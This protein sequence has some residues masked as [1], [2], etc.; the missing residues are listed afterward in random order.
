M[1]ISNSQSQASS[2]NQSAT[3]PNLQVPE[4][5]VLAAPTS[6]L[7]TSSADIYNSTNQVSINS[8]G[9]TTFKS[10]DPSKANTETAV[11]QKPLAKSHVKVLIFGGLVIVACLVATWLMTLNA[12]KNRLGARL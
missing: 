9:D 1:D 4:G 11:E 3:S 5:Q 7:Q 2:V 6:S 8:V 10:F 12:G